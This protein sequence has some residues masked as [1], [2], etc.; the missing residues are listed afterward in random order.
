MKNRIF[1]I[2]L[3]LILLLGGCA[4]PTED[5]AAT[6]A[7]APAATAE[8]APETE[9]EVLLDWQDT[10]ELPAEYAE[11]FPALPYGQ[12]LARRQQDGY[13][14]I[15]C[16]EMGQGELLIY[17]DMLTEAG[18]AG[19]MGSYRKEADSLLLRFDAMIDAESGHFL[20]TYGMWPQMIYMLKNPY[21]SRS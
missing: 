12:E 1:I 4:A 2:S 6:P 8:P 13:I 5:P 21:I 15:E 9:G 7:P 18:F 19:S 20:L 11:H 14:T 10:P 3:A 17:C 16:D